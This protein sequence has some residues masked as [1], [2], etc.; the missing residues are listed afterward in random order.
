MNYEPLLEELQ[1]GGC[2]E[3]CRQPGASKS[4]RQQPSHRA[5]ALGS[6]DVD[7]GCAEVWVFE[8]LKQENH[9]A[10]SK[11]LLVVR[12][13][14]CLFVVDAIQQK[15]CSRSVLRVG[16]FHQTLFDQ[17]RFEQRRDATVARC[18]RGNA[19]RETT[20]TLRTPG[21]PQIIGSLAKM[22]TA[23][24]GNLDLCKASISFR[25]DV[26]VSFFLFFGTFPVSR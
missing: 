2:V 1:V 17:I 8:A 11:G 15:S 6:R 5:F 18:D 4:F 14:D 22:G 7:Y 13:V 9:S 23:G 25:K 19:C 21:L 10:K 16:S 3:P 12:P 24:T 20:Q 26:P